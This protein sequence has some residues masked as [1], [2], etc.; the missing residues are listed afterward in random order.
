MTGFAVVAVVAVGVGA[1]ALVRR[2]RHRAACRRLGIGARRREPTRRGARLDAWLEPRLRAADLDWPVAE[3][4][5]GVAVSGV[6]AV[7]A[8]LAGHPEVT[9]LTVLGM[10]AA[11]MGLHLARDRR[12][13][14]TEADLPAL[15]EAVARSLRSGAA[16]PVALREAATS[17][18]AAAEALGHVLADADRGLGLAE[19]LDRWVPRHPRPAVRLVVGALTVALVAGGSPARGVDGV[20]A[21]LRERAEVEREARSLATQARASALV[22]TLAPLGFGALGVLGD[23]RSA[24]FLLGSPAGLACLVAG[25]ILDGLGAAWMHRIARWPT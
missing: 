21:T 22:V 13:R 20:A 2:W 16:L 18:S 10:A 7:I 17:P 24:G 11:A 12:S 1:P 9:G 19:A 8:G 25:L 15:L 4:V 5:R 23:E 6:L 14:R 3:V